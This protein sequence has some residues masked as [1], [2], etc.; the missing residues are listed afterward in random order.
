MSRYEQPAYE[1][2]AR[3]DAYEIRSYDSYLVAETTVRGSYESTGNEAFRRLAGFIF[4]RNSS[5][6]KMKMTVPVTHEPLADGG[7]RYRFVME[8][9]YTE[10]SLPAPVDEA[11]A[12]VRL[13]AG[14]YAAL[15]YRG[16]RDERRFRRAEAKLRDALACDA[17]A[18]DGPAM[19]AV[20]D[21][22]YV[23]APLRRN[24]V[25]IPVSWPAPS[26]G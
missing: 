22:P 3:R 4:G 16:G 5:G 2:V 25:L 12:V 14:S 1:V 13:P 23:P 18:P 11:V 10:D 26:L 19:S 17:I 7:H 21:G 20:Y 8:R 15:P 9:A 24:E 6:V